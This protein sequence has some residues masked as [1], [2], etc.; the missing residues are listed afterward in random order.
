MSI[1]ES[2]ITQ[3]KP[4][5]AAVA[6]RFRRT[7]LYPESDGKPMADNTR[8]FEWI[9]LIKKGLDD[10]FK[11]DLNVFI[12]GDL[13]WY[14]VKGHP[15]VNIA[16]D[17]LVAFGRPKGHRGSYKQ[18]EE[19]GVAPQVVFEIWSP[20]NSLRERAKKLL[21]YERYG[22]EEYYTY[23]P[24]TDIMLG[25][26]RRGRKL[27]V[28]PT[29]RDRVSP[30]LQIRFHDTN[31]ST[32]GTWKL[33]YPNGRPF[34]RFESVC[35]QRDKAQQQAETERAAREAAQQQAE[36]AQQ[37][38]EAAQQQAEVAQRQAELDRAAKEAAWAKLRALGIDPESL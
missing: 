38:A 27:E 19:G 20:N 37:Q 5:R 7:I 8:Q 2:Q 34:E 12:A 24:E 10:L 22:V 33:F 26:Q 4:K 23:D 31:S 36:A 3:A 1:R 25:W 18:W 15:R 6:T 21:F 35:T 14:P 9:V 17:V 29:M 13:L 11:D 28:I 16:P 30:R 32:N